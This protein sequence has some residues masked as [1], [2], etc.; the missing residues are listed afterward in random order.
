MKTARLHYEQIDDHAHAIGYVCITWAVLEVEVDKLLTMLAPLEFGEVSE[1]I[2]G[3]SNIRDKIKMLKALA[4]ARKPEGADDWYE[5]IEKI[6]NLIDGDL[7]STR[8]R[9][10]HDLWVQGVTPDLKV[11][12][13][14][15]VRRTR[16]PRVVN[17]QSRKRRLA[18][19]KDVPITADEI[20]QFAETIRNVGVRLSVLAVHYRAHLGSLALA[21]V[22]APPSPEK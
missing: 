10:A 14:Y 5:D 8:N 22:N 18:V 7:R 9:Y 15:V 17:E 6:I 19:F 12:N 20:W 11:K 13:F 1:S 16:G 2:L 3:N 21:E 4:F